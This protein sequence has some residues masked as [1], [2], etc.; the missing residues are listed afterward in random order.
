MKVK[1]IIQLIVALAFVQSCTDDKPDS[2]APTATNV[3]DT[4]NLCCLSSYDI[5]LEGRHDTINKIYGKDKI[6]HGRWVN[7][8]FNRKTHSSGKDSTSTN[9]A[10]L[11]RIKTEEGL[12]RFNQRQGFWKFYEADGSLKDSVEYRNDVPLKNNTHSK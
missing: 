12:Y 4:L 9:L 7:Y 5:D 8:A 11:P 3:Y 6:K 2:T 1:I 10:D